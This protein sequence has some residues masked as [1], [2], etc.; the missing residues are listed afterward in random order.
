M[1]A[2]QCDGLAHQ[3]VVRQPHV[4]VPRA[5]DLLQDGLSGTAVGR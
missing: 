5:E 4:A 2:F 1:G 3:R